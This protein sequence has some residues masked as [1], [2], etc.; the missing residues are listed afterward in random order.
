MLARRTLLSIMGLAPAAAI[1]G[2]DGALDLSGAHQKPSGYR[3]G[4]NQGKPFAD[5]LRRLADDIEVGN[6]HL[7]GFEVRS[8]AGL[9]EFLLHTVTIE[10]VVN[11]LPPAA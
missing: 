6:T 8:K 3:F 1:A 9:E 11:E 7:Q 4:V 5:A 10:V 2:E